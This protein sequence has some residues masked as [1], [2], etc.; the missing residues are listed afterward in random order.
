MDGVKRKYG[1]DNKEYLKIRSYVQVSIGW[2]NFVWM[3]GDISCV[4]NDSTSVYL[5]ALLSFSPSLLL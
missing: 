1:I 4:V 5:G 3:G 2:H